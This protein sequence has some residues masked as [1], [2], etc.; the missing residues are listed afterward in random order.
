MIAV[1]RTAPKRVEAAVT[2]PLPQRLLF[3]THTWLWLQADSSRLGVQARHRIQRASEVRFSAV[4]ALE[5]AIKV[6]LGK[7]TLPKD[8]DINEELDF[9][10]FLPLPMEI[11]HADQV[12][13]LRPLHRDPFDRLLVAQ[14]IVEGLTLVTADTQLAAYG[15]S[16]LDARL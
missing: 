9:C 6:A 2:S 5:I 4:S 14:A 12:R 16:V 13:R 1:R 15:V 8:A 7:L 10:G 3:D 11:V